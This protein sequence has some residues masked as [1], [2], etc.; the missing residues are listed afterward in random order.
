MIYVINADGKGWRCEEDNYTPITGETVA[1]TEP[2]FTPTIQELKDQKRAEIQKE[3]CR[4]RDAGALVDG[5]LFDTDSGA[6]IAYLEL[7]M[8]IMQNPSY[9]T[10]WKASGNT[11]VTMDAALFD[12]VMVAGKAL[13]TSV[14]AWQAGKDIEID[15]ADTVGKVNA[16]TAIYQ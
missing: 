10:S 7:A 11:W 3:K 2:L 5:V 14:F 16:I 8:Q 6:R 12:K 1:E 9:S 13:L 4:V 15:A